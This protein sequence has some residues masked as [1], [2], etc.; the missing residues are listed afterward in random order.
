M[1]KGR[2]YVILSAIIVL[3]V[4]YAAVS[5]DVF[6]RVTHTTSNSIPPLAKDDQDTSSSQQDNSAGA[7]ISSAIQQITCRSNI[8]SDV[9]EIDEHKIQITDETQIAEI[10]DT[11]LEIEWTSK[12]EGDW[13]KYSV[14]RPDH[15]MEI[16]TSGSTVVINLFDTGFVAILTDD[17][18]QRYEI[19]ESYYE[20]L[21]KY[22]QISEG[23]I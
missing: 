7:L 21:K 2:L 4:I 15:S 18:W 16:Q 17:R 9:H 14:E 22:C 6:P 23:G 1:K 8:G 11:I 3:F 20:T 5:S 12:T 10:I 19:P 13:P